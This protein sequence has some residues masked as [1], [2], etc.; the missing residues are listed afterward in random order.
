[1]PIYLTKEEKLTAPMRLVSGMWWFFALMMLN[2]YTA[3]LAAFM[4][5]SR[6]NTGIKSIS[7]LADQNKIQFGTQKGGSTE[8]FFRESNDSVYRLAWSKMIQ[9]QPSVFT[10]T[11]EAG[12]ERVK[13][14]KG[15][16]AFLME[17]TSLEYQVEKNCDLESVGSQI[18]EKH[19]GI[20]V[21][22]GSDYRSNLSWAILQLGEKGEL[23][24]LKK[25]WWSKKMTCE[26]N[27]E[28][29]GSDLSVK[30]LGGVFLVLLGGLIIAYILG[31][32]EFL[33]NIQ[34][35]AVEERLLHMKL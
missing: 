28:E 17:T 1:M 5:T 3:N 20:A 2:S 6:Q 15:D 26:Q 14:A 27:E 9:T 35:I 30:E 29:D 8:S 31:I 12:V 25:T 7:D 13:K 24:E 21:P 34:K 11:P 18:G 19:Y 33:W 4:T 23:F 22:I 32:G 10:D 16:Y